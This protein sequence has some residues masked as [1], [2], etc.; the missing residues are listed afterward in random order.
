MKKTILMLAM[1]SSSFLVQKIKEVKT[2]KIL[3]GMPLQ[4]MT[5]AIQSDVNINGNNIHV[6]TD[7]GKA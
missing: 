4:C 7:D 5:T 6:K 3:E 1:A 2:N